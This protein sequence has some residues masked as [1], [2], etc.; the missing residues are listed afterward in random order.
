[1]KAAPV[2]ERQGSNATP[3]RMPPIV[4]EPSSPSL[5]PATAKT[6]N[7]M[8]EIDLD[9]VYQYTLGAHAAYSAYYNT[10]FLLT[11]AVGGVTLMTAGLVLGDS[12]I[13]QIE[14]QITSLLERPTAKSGSIVWTVLHAIY[15]PSLAAVSTGFLASLRLRPMAVNF[16]QGKP[17]P[18]SLESAGLT[19]AET[20]YT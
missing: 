10:V 20:S 1:M 4:D 8:L 3:S 7:L 15:K 14:S 5:P 12:P 6:N 9:K 2:A 11:G 18:A 13:K 19:S 16:L 17:K